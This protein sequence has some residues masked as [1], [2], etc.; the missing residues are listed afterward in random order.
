MRRVYFFSPIIIS[1][2]FLQGI[3]G[4][5]EQAQEEVDAVTHPTTHVSGEIIVKFKPE[6]FDEEGELVADSILE[7][8]ER[9]QVVSIERVFKTKPVGDLSN[10]Y[11][12]EFSGDIDI[13]EVVQVYTEDPNVVYAEPNYI[14]RT[15][16]AD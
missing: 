9:Y 12:I 4:C 5:Q 6:A 14:M 16:G 2:L 7:L 10:I 8:N 1:I 11:K 3:G 13:M 15:Q